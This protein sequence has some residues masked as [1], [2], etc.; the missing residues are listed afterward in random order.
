MRWRPPRGRRVFAPG[1]GAMD[2]AMKLILISPETDHP[3]EHAVVAELFAAGLERF[4]V[5]KPHATITHLAAYLERIP[6]ESRSRIVLHH[7]HELVAA[8]GLGGRHW[9]DDR[10]AGTA[11]V[12]ATSGAG[13]ARET[14]T[15]RS[16]HDL[17]TL[18]SCMGNF[19]SVFF[20]PVFPSISKPGYG[21]AT[22]QIGEA[23]GAILRLRSA[24]ER[25]TEV[26]ALGG[27]TADT[28]PRALAL[29]FDG[30]AVVGAVWQASDPVAAFRALRAVESSGVAT[31]RI[32]SHRA[33]L[34]QHGV[35][36]SGARQESK[37]IG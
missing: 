21:P 16:C 28:A 4:H 15:S 31:D 11:P 32:A 22:S 9:R 1:R 12:G 27:I 18:R 13:E 3:R 14:L 17:A 29:G 23:L 36:G 30:V 5:R 6:V 33:P 34:R 24:E 8:L 7:H 26:I 20:G 25:R 19:D 37:T 10:G 2:R 35:W